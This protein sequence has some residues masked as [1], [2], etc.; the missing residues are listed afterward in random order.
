MSPRTGTP[1]A[2]TRRVYDDADTTEQM[3]QDASACRREAH[4]S[5]VVARVVAVPG[6]ATDA[7]LRAPRQVARTAVSVSDSAA[8]F[9]SRLFE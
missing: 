4:L 1:T 7:V 3:A 8:R 6:M 9:A 5:H 2:S